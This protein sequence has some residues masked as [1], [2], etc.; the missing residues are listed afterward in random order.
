MKFSPC[1]GQ[2]TQEGTHCNG[3]GRTHQEVAETKRMIVELV[4]FARQMEYENRQDF[5]SFVAHSILF[6][7]ENS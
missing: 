2:C 4:D 7:L 6:R 3:C 1:T 5:A